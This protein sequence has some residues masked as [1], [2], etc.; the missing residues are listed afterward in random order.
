MRTKRTYHSLRFKITVGLLVSLVAVST[1][2]SCLRYL[3]FRRLLME[4]LEHSAAITEE[5]VRAQ[6]AA[7]FRS[8]LLLSIGSIIVISVIANLMMSQIV[9]SRL[10][11]FLQV[12]KQ[13]G[14]GSL[15]ARVVIGGHDEIS[16]LAEAFNRMT[17]EL[18]R[19]DE[20]L[21]TLNSLAISVSQSLNLQ[22]VLGS[23][24][25]EVLDLV[26][27][28]AGW[29]TM[30]DDHGE[31]FRLAATRGLSEEAALAHAQ[32]DWM[33]CVCAGVFELGRCHV[34]HDKPEDLCPAVESLR[35]EG[36]VFRACVP[37]KPKDRVLGIMSLVGV[38]SQNM[39]VFTE[40]SL[41][42]LTAI[43][44]QIGSAIE[45]ASLYEELRQTEMLRRQLMERGIDLQEEERKRIAR[46]LHDQTSQRLTSILLTLS[47]LGEA[48]SPDEVRTYV[49]DLRDMA[50]QTLEEVHNLALELR[51]RLLDDLGLVAA[52][53]HYLGEFRDRYHV[54]VDLQVLGLDSERLPPQTETALYRIAQE[55]LTNVARHAQAHR[56]GVLLENRDSSVMLI[57][58]DDGR[59][60]D[61][62][63]VMG[64]H[65]HEENL[66]LYGMR[67]RA[68]L[69]GGT[70]TVES[71]PGA[72]GTSVFVEI[73]QE[74]GRSDN[75]K[76]PP[77]G[78]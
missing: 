68:F 45:N 26:R 48:E 72:A 29:V 31:G 19:Q 13:V 1:V 18:Q 7:Y 39:W 35:R 15:D 14:P 43:G 22:E 62:L 65:V 51:P 20:K 25:D 8:R 56:V 44:R 61:V 21:T 5:V 32:C 27:L 60:F 73:P 28:G 11:R 34:F 55:A 4:N 47:V 50:V 49:R 46:E 74:R 16:E 78:R 38:A 52:L 67:E 17:T 41:E 77:A 76:D 54:P 36:V 71:R 2:T 23:A 12:V 75:E 63:Q 64:S 66:G 57:V 24:L 69:L 42:T 70:F 9:I 58:E 40:D 37:L 30:R 6:L 33:R 53:R 59:G 10:K 3:G